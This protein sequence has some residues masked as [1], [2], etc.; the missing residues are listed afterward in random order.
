[1]SLGILK[2]VQDD[3]LGNRR[4]RA[5]SRPFLCHQGV[6]ALPGRTAHAFGNTGFLTIDNRDV[7]NIE[8]GRSG[9]FGI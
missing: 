9:W 6:A 4:G 5:L 3:D 1:M 7:G 8:T 2:R